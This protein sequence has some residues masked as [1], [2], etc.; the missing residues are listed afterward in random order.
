MHTIGQDLRFAVR[1]LAKKRGFTSFA[2]TVLA[3]GI[4]ANTSMFSL[5]NVVLLRPLPYRDAGRL[6]MVWENYSFIGFPMNTPAP[7]NFADWKA[8]SRSFEDLAAMAGRSLSLAGPGEPLKINAYEVTAN[9][10][11]V[12]GV[13]PAFGR[14]FS[15]D[16]DKPGGARVAILSHGFWLRR[17]GGDAQTVGRQ[18]QLNDANYTVIGV[19][20]KGFLFPDRET[21]MWVPLR[22]TSRDLANHGSHYLH[23]VG[24]LKRGVTL[25]AAN[26]ELSLIARDLAQ[27]Y[28]MS[29][30]SVGAYAMLLR[31]YLVGDLRVAILVLLGAVGFVLLIACANVANLA[32][33]RAAGRQRELAV[34]MAL[35]A[36]GGRIIRQVLTE[37]VLLST[38]A[39]AAGLLL[40]V[41][42]FAF[43]RQLIPTG[44]ADVEQLRLD[45]RMLGFTGGVSVF[46]GILFGIAP[47]LR[48]SGMP[49]M[50]VL[51]QAGERGAAGGAGNRM[52]HGL[53]IA[54]I[55][56]AVVLL[57][58]AGLMIESFLKLRGIDLGFRTEKVL[59][60]ETP[61]PRPRYAD[62]S[63]RTAFYDQVLDRLTR[64][65]GVVSAGCTT[66][67]PYTNRGG[68]RGFTI[69]GRPQPK[70][71]EVYD[72]NTR[73]I[74]KDYLET[75]GV[76]LKR[77]RLFDVHDTLDSMP[78]A[79]INET[80]ARQFWPG[81]DPI[82]KRIE[83][84]DNDRREPWITIVGI[85][86]DMRQMGLDQLPR[87]E[88]YFPYRQ[89]S[90]YSPDYF[91]VRATGDPMQ[92]A[93]A[94]REAIWAVDKQQAV[95][96]IMPLE[97]LVDEDL[98]PRRLQANLLGGFAGMALLLASLGIYAVLS[99]AVAQRTQEIGVRVAL[100]AQKADILRIIVGQ[101]ARLIALG[102]AIGIAAALAL[103]R[104]LQHLLYGLSAT[105]ALTFAGAVIV[106]GGIALLACY[107]PARRA[108]RLDPMQALH[109]E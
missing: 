95:A 8:Q 55:A 83:T 81:E 22:L 41:W 109:Y 59:A 13:S 25:G 49:V 80:M 40:S 17:F 52:R 35:G 15:D 18:I 96:G 39:G 72:A 24:R 14:I 62:F 82:G 48:V 4:A 56:L 98:A 10:F 23:V 76:P 88:M 47:A 21:E 61:L 74:S 31:D 73:V 69:E 19:M 9:L 29:N 91:S 63:R 97:D 57:C 36:G 43:L 33:A 46:A 79:L 100:G 86:G 90:F 50:D 1:M 84:G 51:K 68:T 12:L 37:S 42:G 27:R 16:E 44:L 99:F 32:L 7:G 78:T 26:A 20:P 30:T 2:V 94:V 89:Q 107:I 105:D 11:P 103:T 85:V 64:L 28:P 93:E 108:M 70:P 58:G 102:I 65:P 38:T 45:W 60:V 71:G 106:L 67:L 75:L 53:V 54:E 104:A 66:W 101:G 34:R 77:G 6:V 3:L 92:L 87:A 5:A